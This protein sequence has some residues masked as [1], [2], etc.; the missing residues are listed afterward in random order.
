VTPK[1]LRAKKEKDLA[2]FLTKWAQELAALKIKASIGQCQNSSKITQMR[3]DI[4]R[5]KTIYREREID[6]ASEAK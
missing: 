5:I 3:R 4:A 2:G 6:V 1:E